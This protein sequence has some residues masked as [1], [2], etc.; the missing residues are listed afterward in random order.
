[1]F[2]T[3]NNNIEVSKTVRTRSQI[4]INSFRS[5]LNLLEEVHHPQ[6]NSLYTHI[7]EQQGEQT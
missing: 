1:M 6:R 7:G 4:I 5:N 3:K 2:T